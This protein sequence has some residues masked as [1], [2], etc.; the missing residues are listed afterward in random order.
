MTVQDRQWPQKKKC[1]WQGHRQQRQ[2][3]WG[4]TC[5][6]EGRTF[7]AKVFV[8]AGHQQMAA[9]SSHPP[10]RL[11][12]GPCLCVHQRRQFPGP[13]F[14]SG[15]AAVAS[16]T[17]TTQQ[18]RQTLTDVCRSALPSSSLCRL[19]SDRLLSF[20]LPLCVLR[21]PCRRS[22]S[23]RPPWPMAPGGCV[24]ARYGAWR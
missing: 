8:A 15:T 7:A 17:P 2:Q 10:C 16:P 21:W 9:S 14:R 13:L 1:H 20:P 24:L 22:F 5:K 12:C 23:C 3:P 19:A 18:R 6:A 4:G 11:C